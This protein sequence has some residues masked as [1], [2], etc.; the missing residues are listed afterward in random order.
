[1]SI[2]TVRWDITEHL[3]SDA[4]VAAYLEAVFEVGDLT[5]FL[6]DG[7]SD[8]T[9]A[10]GEPNRGFATRSALDRLVG[11]LE[12]VGG[13]IVLVLPQPLVTGSGSLWDKIG[14]WFGNTFHLKGDYTLPDYPEQYGELCEAILRGRRDVLV[15]TGDIHWSRLVRIAHRGSASRN[16]FE[17]TSSPLSR[18]PS[19]P[20]GLGDPS[21]GS[22]DGRLEW[23]SGS[24]GWDQRFAAVDR[25]T[26][27]TAE[28]VRGSAGF[29]VRLRYF[30]SRDASGVMEFLEPDRFTIA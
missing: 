30:R 27:A 3:G 12:G 18:I 15:L 23:R 8:R 19:L 5:F 26:Y 17:A 14:D 13:P 1:M 6:L 24:T 10:Y 16:V 20:L 29:D 7:R 28:F 22:S 2:K 11:A 25:H 21:V 4:E 9:S